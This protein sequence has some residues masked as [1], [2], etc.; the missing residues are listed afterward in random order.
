[1]FE[2]EPV[3][4]DEPAVRDEFPAPPAPLPD[5][6]VR[7]A[8]VLSPR[9][10]P[11]AERTERADAARGPRLRVTLAGPP[12]AAAGTDV[13][14]L[15]TVANEGGA[16]AEAVTITC[17]LPAGLRHPRGSGVRCVLGDLAPGETRTATLVAR[18][19]A[20]AGSVT[21]TA[22]VTARGGLI[23]QID[24][25]VR[26]DGPRPAP[27]PDR[28]RPAAGLHA[29]VPVAGG[30]ERPPG[31]R[32]RAATARESSPYGRESRETTPGGRR[33]DGRNAA[34]CRGR[35]RRPR[36]MVEERE[37]RRRFGRVRRRPA[38]SARRG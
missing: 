38:E 10:D 34:H 27:R 19:T 2:D 6:A 23:A 14:L 22:E 37:R 16:P 32:N 5:A 11:P 17:P 12:S 29:D 33:S 9:P 28:R 31:T 3:F 26:I 18:V 35:L 13:R 4:D 36:V 8:Q 25:A 1:M 21:P 7:P 24:A 15:V 20:A 30:P